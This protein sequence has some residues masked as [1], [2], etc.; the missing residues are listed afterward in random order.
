M[1]PEFRYPTPDVTLWV[2]MADIFALSGKAGVADWVGSR[3]LRGYRPVARLKEGVS[4]EQAQAEM[5][6]IEERLGQQHREDSGLGVLL[7]PLR[8]EMV[9]K[10]E[11][12]LMMLLMGVGFVLLI[13][14]VNVANLMLSRA[15]ARSKEMAIRRA[16]GANSRRLARQVLTESMLLALIGGGLGV[17][18]AMWGVESFLRLSPAGVPRLESVRIDTTVLLFA[19]ATAAATGLLFGLAPALRTARGD[20]YGS[21]REGSRDAGDPSGSRRAR[22]ILVVAEVA[23][24]VVLVVGAGLM[25]NSFVRL[26][27]VDPGFA[28]DRLLTL[29]VGISL[30]R[31]P[32]TELQIRYLDSVL[33]RI[34]VVPGVEEVGA[35]TSLPPNHVQQKDG[36]SLDDEPPSTSNASA[37]FMPAT[38]R[39]IEALGLPV[40]S[41]RTFNETDGPSQTPVAVINR[42]LSEAFFGGTDP[43]GHRINISGRPRMIVGVVGDTKFEGL[44]SPAGFQVY[45]PFAQNPFPGMRLVVRSNVEPSSLIG[46]VREAMGSVDADESGSGYMPMS[47]ILSASINEPRFYTTLVGAFGVV[48]LAL[49]SV[50]IFGVISYS[51]SRRTKEIG[52]RVALGASKSSVVGMVLQESLRVIVTG[53][54][55]GVAAAVGLTRLLAGLLYEVRPADPATIIGVVLLLL[56]VGVIAALIPARRAAKVDPMV[57]LRYE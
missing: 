19:L 11:R 13:A 43:L 25:I 21:L 42:S 36:F 52:V 41:G 2:S 55:L 26:M 6:A 3:S 12:P 45:V 30:A 33:E 16:L 40:L 23:L 38:P 32:E 20:L 37:W 44:A 49:A 14:C 4:L 53:L 35:S 27:R 51:V 56:G 9:G 5:D 1:P 7:K 28:P 34:R 54:V 29:W 47:Q 17:L 39:F 46:S 31:Y 15:T 18:L 8:Q 50:G 24:A 48:A 22:Q 10:V 57:A